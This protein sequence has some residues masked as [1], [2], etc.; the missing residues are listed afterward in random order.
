[1]SQQWCKEDH[2]SVYTI[3]IIIMVHAYAHKIIDIN[4]GKCSGYVEPK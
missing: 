4:L 1:M 3:I 2:A